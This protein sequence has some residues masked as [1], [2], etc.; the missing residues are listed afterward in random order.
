MVTESTR[1]LRVSA[2]SGFE[3]SGNP[4]VASGL[5]EFLG[6]G[7]GSQER[8]WG[9]IEA[10]GERIGCD[11]VLPFSDLSERC[12]LPFC[13]QVGAKIVVGLSRTLRLAELRQE[14]VPEEDLPA[15]AA[16]SPGL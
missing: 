2:V 1:K 14:E 7:R 11:S 13:E 12:G 4:E 6:H 15:R 5:P 9:R 8:L 3:N 16:I 10:R